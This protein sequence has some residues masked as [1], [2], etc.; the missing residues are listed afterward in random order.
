LSFQKDGSVKNKLCVETFGVVCYCDNLLTPL[1]RRA[2]IKEVTDGVIVEGMPSVATMLAIY[3][4]VGLH[5]ATCAELL[6][7]D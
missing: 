4:D 1:S 7:T 2:Q 3:T 5:L 6:K